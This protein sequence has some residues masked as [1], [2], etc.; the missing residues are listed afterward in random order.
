[1]VGVARD[2]EEAV[3]LLGSV[4]CDVL[5]LDIE[6]PGLSGFGV[7]ERLDKTPYVVFTT[8]HADFA[9]DA[10]EAGA[11]DFLIKPIAKDRFQKSIERVS[12]F[13]KKEATAI[14]TQRRHGLF[15]SEKENNFYV[16]FA[17][18]VYVS[19]H[20]NYCAIHA[21]ERDYVT[22]CSLKAM[23]ERLPQGDFVR[24]YKQYIV[25][26]NLIDRVQSD[27]NGSYTIHLKDEDATQLPVGRAYLPRLKEI[28][29]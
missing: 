22:Y 3:T 20:E 16:R 25:N 13:F 24:I 28:M 21:A 7:L 10:F 11:V 17:N 19:S 26:V 14:A 27:Q 23:E 2:G 6:M 15:I 4:E 5:F 18:I 9:L 29:A 1:M 12:G 8:S